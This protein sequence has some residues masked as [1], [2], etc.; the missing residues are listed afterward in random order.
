M[1]SSSPEPENAA[2]T[3]TVRIEQGQQSPR[4]GGQN[5]SRTWSHTTRPNSTSLLTRALAAHNED[6]ERAL[7]ET[8]LKAPELFT[9]L[10]LE[11][12]LTP[13]PKNG[14]STAQT[15]EVGTDEMAEVMPASAY[16]QVVAVSLGNSP[17]SSTVNLPNMAQAS[18]VIA[19]HNALLSSSRP[20]STSLER[21]DKE[22][23]VEVS[24][25]GTYSTNPGDTALPPS[26]DLHAPITLDSNDPPIDGARA[27]YRSWR[28]VRPGIASEKA[29]SIGEQ[30]SDISHGQV[31]RSIT[32]AM[33]GAEHNNRSRKAS[34]TLGFFK[35]GLPEDKSK[36]KESR[37]R[38]RSKEGL[39]R[40]KGAVETEIGKRR[41]GQGPLQES[42]HSQRSP[43]YR[44]SSA[45]SP[46]DRSGSVN[47]DTNPTA[48]LAAREGYFDASHNIETVS[49]EQLQSMPPQLLA[50]IRKHHNLTPGAGKGS[51]FSRSIPVTVSERLQSDLEEDG[52]KSSE[53]PETEIEDYSNE[54]STDPTCVKSNDED[55]ESGEEQISSALFVPH[56]T[57]LD[58]SERDNHGLENVVRPRPADLRRET[59]TS[60][61]WLEEHKVPSR[62][63][64][65]KYVGQEGP[66]RPLPVPVPSR[67]YSKE[68]KP[69]PD[70]VPDFE[71]LKVEH[72]IKDDEGVPTAEEESSVADTVDA[73]PA[74]SSTLAH[75]IPPDYSQHFHDHQIDPTQPLEAIEL[76]PY[77]H[78]V[79]GH[80][81][82]WRFSKRAVAKQ[83]SN[84]ENEFYEKVERYHPQL[85]KFLP[86]YIG[87]LNV[88]FEKQSRRKS[89]RKDDADGAGATERQEI[90]QDRLENQNQ[91]DSHASSTE[92]GHTSANGQD[93]QPRMVSQSMN[94]SSVPIPTVTFADNRHII[95]KSFMQPHPRLKDAE[96]RSKSD[97]TATMLTQVETPH[98]NG[99]FRD[100][101]DRPTLADKHA[102]SWGATT[103]NKQLRNQVFGEAFLQQPIPIQRHKKPASQQRSLPSR[104][105]GSSLRNSNSESSL[106]AAQQRQ[107]GPNIQAP[108]ES[109][110]RKAMKTAAQRRNGPAPM[111]STDSK[112]T[113]SVTSPDEAETDSDEKAGTSAPEPE[114][115]H[116]PQGKRQRRYSS[117]G[118]RRKPAEVAEDRG[119]LKYFEEADDAGYKGDIEEDVFPMDLDSAQDPLNPSDPSLQETSAEANGVKS[120]SSDIDN[121]ENSKAKFSRPIDLRKL[122]GNLLDIPRPV[123]PKEA[124]TTHNSRVVYFLLLED[125]TAGMKRPCIMDLKMGTRQYGVEA[126]EKKQKSQQR[127]SEATTSRE[128]GVRVCGLQ[129]WDTNTEQYVFLDKYYGRNLK[130]GRQFQDAL[131]RFLY[132][133]VD[134]SSVLRH[135]P[136]ILAKLS[137]LEVLI[138]G[139][140]GYRF[141]AASLLVFYDGDPR[142]ADESDSAATERDVKQKNEVD[143]KIADFANSV[144]KE[145]FRS[146]EKPCPPR[147]PDQPDKG[148]LRGLR[149]L[150][151]YFLAIQKEIQ[152][153]EMGKHQEEFINGHDGDEAAA[154]DLDGGGVSY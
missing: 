113:G 34:H 15:A 20:R 1:S 126:N 117:G 64:E 122:S 106:N 10:A 108:E 93:N 54:D 136:S 56:H 84:R 129:V 47:H 59:S 18:S 97:G 70:K 89:G 137:K 114:I 138:R 6:D 53:A 16:N 51:S 29:W 19:S 82:L 22:K 28:D 79:G 121:S 14:V 74:G 49:D 141:Y 125:L 98:R 2:P 111:T 152:A 107:A 86:R 127:K 17:V 41:L 35:E 124:Q 103:V 3:D 83:L 133:G 109:I 46:L 61:Q 69:Q 132:D 91:D 134:Y 32:E 75:Q 149:T 27:K 154:M 90:A 145:D 95:P 26:P 23:K 58:S 112:Q 139:L 148:F 24:A 105:G 147:H 150:K 25:N 146:G 76:I 42:S 48:G 143:F 12:A 101:Q 65:K 99:N 87:V 123:N 80:T 102:A 151:K 100:V 60:Q 73:T 30:G 104:Q 78:Q 131:T 110:R 40:G 130:A 135:I 5:K 119:D 11:S 37:S 118:L 62:E 116:S 77:R 72:V 38:G 128:L 8:D 9:N 68:Q 33:T 50:E 43:T 88:T 52:L 39:S 44:E 81:T 36:K 67:S 120:A 142:E 4:D 96:R 21:T 7:N 85:L 45:S 92:N 140:V 66:S 31:E 71:T 144:T 13:A 94:S 57:R 63:V 153:K 115:I 55:E